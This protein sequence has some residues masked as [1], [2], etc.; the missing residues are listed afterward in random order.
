MLYSYT[1]YPR[2]IKME[3]SK[4][5][6]RE[7]LILALTRYM[8]STLIRSQIG[9]NI[10]CTNVVIVKCQ[11]MNAKV[12]TRNGQKKATFFSFFFSFLFSFPFSENKKKKKKIRVANNFYIKKYQPLTYK[13]YAEDK[14][15]KQKKQ[16][17]L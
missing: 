16:R 14:Q 17:H 3:S 1:A 15:Q 13:K 12:F 5:K 2:K 11:H 9:L 7:T 10:S 6:P 8:N 4:R